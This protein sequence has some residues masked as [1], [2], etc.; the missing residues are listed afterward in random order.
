MKK[1]FPII[2]IILLFHSCYKPVTQN[3]I[4]GT[5]YL[6][7]NQKD[8]Y[9]V[10]KLLEDKN[11]YI[12][13]YK[14]LETDEVFIDIGKW[15]YSKFEFSAA[16]IIFYDWIERDLKKRKKIIL[17]KIYKVETIG[18][19]EYIVLGGVEDKPNDFGRKRD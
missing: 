7:F 5:Y 4:I 12:H 10:L 18:M 8:K 9:E 2:V 19:E 1:I 3:E 15:E 14:D 17:H 16:N 13:F 11:Q 6:L